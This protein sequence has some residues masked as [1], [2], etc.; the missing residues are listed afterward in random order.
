[1]NK[2]AITSIFL[3][4]VLYANV[5]GN[6]E[7][8][9]NN[10]YK[11]NS[12]K[13][14]AKETGI[15][16]EVEVLGF[17]IGT[18]LVAQDD[19]KKFTSSNV[20]AQYTT[21]AYKGIKGEFRGKASLGAQL[22]LGTKLIYEPVKGLELSFASTFNPGINGKN[23]EY[24]NVLTDEGVTIEKDSETKLFA[25]SYVFE[26]KYT[27]DTLKVTGDLLLQHVN[28]RY[29]KKK[30][31]QVEA[32]EKNIDKLRKTKEL[33]EKNKE[34]R[35]IAKAS[36]EEF[37]KVNVTEEEAN[38]IKTDYTTKEEELKAKS[39]EKDKK[40]KNVDELQNELNELKAQVDANKITEEVKALKENQDAISKELDNLKQENAK[41]T[42][43]KKAK[44]E[45]KAKKEQEKNSHLVKSKQIK[46]SI[47]Q[48]NKDIETLKNEISS[49]EN[50]LKNL[51][52]EQEIY[53]QIDKIDEKI[54]KYEKELE[55]SSK[56]YV[57]LQKVKT[58]YEKFLKAEEKEQ[59]KSFVATLLNK[60]FSKLKT[61]TEE[62][63]KEYEKK[64]EKLS[65]TYSEL[66]NMK[67]AK[68]MY[69]NRLESKDIKKQ[70][71]NTKKKIKEE[72]EKLEI[73][74]IADRIVLNYI[75]E[76]ELTIST[77][78]NKI[79]EL[80]SK[81]EENQNEI[82]K[83]YKEYD[84]KFKVITRK[85]TLKNL[86]NEPSKKA[87]IIQ[88]KEAELE[89]AK[90]S[91]KKVS[92]EENTLKNDFDALSNK[93]AGIENKKDKK[94]KFDEDNKNLTDNETELK[95]EVFTGEIKAED[96]EKKLKEVNAEI[97]KNERNKEEQIKDI[98]K[99]PYNKMEENTVYV[100]A[101]LGVEYTYK[102]LGVEGKL[103]LGTAYKSVKKDKE[104][105]ESKFMPYVKL[106]GKINYN[107]EVKKNIFIV[108]ELSGQ[109]TADKLTTSD[110]NIKYSLTPKVAFKCTPV[111]NLLISADLELSN[112]FEKVQYKESALGTNISIKY[113][114]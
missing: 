81:I 36:K 1:M 79:K 103:T 32:L 57:D 24:K 31:N 17:K 78:D 101:K 84:N 114:W 65:K 92:D 100:G 14:S 105:V 6:V 86:N 54:A 37:E 55:S 80:N 40:Q 18:H 90:T 41:L 33:L 26:A 15:N 96:V 98:E 85:T 68:E 75:N 108:P 95:K 60:V 43:E 69:E 87:E 110:L 113:M 27:K 111:N 45:L 3:T 104:K 13:F 11:I 112:N 99:N 106:N 97:D 5:H 56:T 39:A 50:S 109:V 42:K 30:P 72:K 70:I 9:N 74:Q 71:E 21:P 67:K 44:E 94:A 29:E 53:K 73:N 59:N 12:N 2:L 88:N 7:A 107:F 28:E 4:S 34:L 89:A 8:F 77:I 19:F 64:D 22:E 38:K 52:K 47:S 82:A 51:K 58:V 76:T 35:E 49:S 48:G 62:K 66:Q 16:A 102:N 83:K 20:Y 25:H 93:K 91:L 61:K 10:Q 23:L 46:D 63:I